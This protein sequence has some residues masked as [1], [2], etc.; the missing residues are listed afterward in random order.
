MIPIKT[1]Q[2]IDSFCEPYSKKL[3]TTTTTKK[4]N[5][6]NVKSNKTYRTLDWYIYIYIFVYVYNL[7]HVD[8]IKYKG[9]KGTHECECKA[10]S[11]MDRLLWFFICD[12]RR[13][14]V[15][16]SDVTSFMYWFAMLLSFSLRSRREVEDWLQ[17]ASLGVEH[18]ACENE[19]NTTKVS[20]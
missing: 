15:S 6:Y 1:F 14:M 20:H 3:S 11:P 19:T 7:R 17:V 2:A 8:L 5:I 16:E 10:V 13:W 18:Q 9:T 12:E 4:K